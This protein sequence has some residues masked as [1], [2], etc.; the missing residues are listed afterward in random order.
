MFNLFNKKS[1]KTVALY[2]A[3]K[4][5]IL[6]LEA[7]PDPVFS[8][9]MVGDGFAVAPVEGIVYAPVSGEVVQLFPTKHAFGIRTAEGLEVLVHVGIDTVQLGGE[10]FTAFVE[11]GSVVTQGQK[12]LEV[13]LAVLEAKGKSTVTPVI[14]TNMTVVAEIKAS[15]A[16]ETLTG[17]LDQPIVDVVLK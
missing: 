12:I 4:G 17:L 7:V 1:A 16:F 15:K 6:A 10:G 5:D 13:D 9:K 2:A 3:M 14:V 8:G 11:K